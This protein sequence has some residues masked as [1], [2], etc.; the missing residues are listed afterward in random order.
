MGVPRF[1]KWVSDNFNDS[2]RHINLEN[3]N[4]VSIDNLYFDANGIL[5]NSVREVFFPGKKRLAKRTT[6]EPTKQEKLDLVFK[7]IIDYIDRITTFVNPKKELFIAIDGTAPVAKQ[8]QQRQ[9][10]YRSANDTDP[11]IMKIFD[12]NAITPGTKFMKQLTQIITDYIHNKKEWNHLK[13]TFSPCTIPGEGEHKIVSYIRS[14][15]KDSFS[16]CMYGLDADLFMLTLSL[17][18]PR[19]FLLRED[20]FTVSW[21]KSWFYFVNINKFAKGLHKKFSFPGMKLKYFIDDFVLISFLL[22]NDFLHNLPAFY[23]LEYSIEF[24]LLIKRE[25][26]GSKRI[27]ELEN[28]FGINTKNLLTLL[29]ELSKYEDQLIHS[30]ADY[31]QFENK[32]LDNSIVKGEFYFEK[33]RNNYYKKCDVTDINTFCRRYIQGLEWVN[34]Y[35]H[36]DPINWQWLFPY[37]HSPLIS[38]LVNWLSLNLEIKSM[39]K[40]KKSSLTENQQLM[41][42]IPPKSYKIIPK[43]LREF[44]THPDLIEYYPDKFDID[45]EGKNRDWQGVAILPFI[46]IK[47]L[48]KIVK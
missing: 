5:H 18:T 36:N 7:K 33:Y 11:E 10:R 42:V 48:I 47:K 26:L 13:V 29:S 28:N 40:V 1:F 17:H 31:Q 19:I 43:Q 44:Y 32:T 21:D 6:S 27:S 37:H 35:Y 8:S 22:G 16:H 14:L 23:D 34:W 15:E 39:S 38:D 46:D 2:I 45:L 25:I 9:R 41:C 12:K 3:E 20:Q 24:I 30:M 4:S